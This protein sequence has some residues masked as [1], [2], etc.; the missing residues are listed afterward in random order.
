MSRTTTQ[1]PDLGY[2]RPMPW[3]DLTGGPR[4]AELEMSRWHPP[5]C[6][7]RSKNWAWFADGKGLRARDVLRICEGCPFAAPA[8]HPPWCSPRST[9]SGAA[10]PRSAPPCSDASQRVN[11][12]GRSSTLLSPHGPGRSPDASA[13]LPHRTSGLLPGVR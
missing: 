3:I 7:L 5:K 6:L 10:S 2:G 13:A 8:S 11:P 9:A 12:S 1:N 4:V